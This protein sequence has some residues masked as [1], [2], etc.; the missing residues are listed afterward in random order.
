MDRLLRIGETM[1]NFKVNDSELRLL[2]VLDAVLETNDVSRASELLA[3]TPSAVSHSLRLLRE[4]FSD[5]LLVRTRG[6]LEPTPLANALQPALR[7]SLT[8][9]AVLLQTEADY[10]PASSS[11][12]FSLAAP[13]YYLFMMLPP[14]VADI[15]RSAPSVDLRFRP[16]GLDVFEQLASG[17]LD[18]VLAGSE[19]ET[20]LGLNRELMRSR[21]ISEP[22]Y[23][24]MRSDHPAA[25]APE[26][27]LEAYLEA[28]HVMVSLAGE[29]VD[30]VDTAL[31]GVG[32]RRRIGA[33]VPSFMAAA[34]Y[35][36]ESDMIATL[37]KTVAARAAERAGGVIRRPPIDLPF[38][39]AHIW[40][41]PRYQHD[42]GH[43]W[44]R[45]RLIDALGP[46]RRD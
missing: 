31:E 11:R 23:C 6:K 27:T 28:P 39:T 21:V 17:E 41:H 8:Q 1:K 13:D 29:T 19:L 14:V 4:R 42:A 35:A 30:A 15:R 37:P 12:Q 46:Y 32:A 40:W 26:L 45:R 43:V 5:P 24:V 9:L 3:V 20:V 10:D 36:T 33:A 34:W 38:S 18:L 44:W 7:Q 25:Q 22:Y 16:V 2:R